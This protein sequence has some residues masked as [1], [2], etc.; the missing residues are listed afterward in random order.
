MD[1]EIENPATCG[2]DLSIGVLNGEN[3]SGIRIRC[4]GIRQ[5]VNIERAGLPD[6]PNDGR[7]GR[8]V[9]AAVDGHIQRVADGRRAVRDLIVERKGVALA[10]GQIVEQVR[11]LPPSVRTPRPTIV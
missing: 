8:V 9:I 2:R 6:R 7:S 5:Q 4:I 3:V 1:A 10:F 11:S